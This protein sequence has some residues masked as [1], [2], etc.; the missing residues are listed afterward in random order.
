[1]EQLFAFLSSFGTW[2]LKYLPPEAVTKLQATLPLWTIG[3]IAVVVAAFVLKVVTHLVFR[4]ILWVALIVLGIIL[5]Q[6]LGVPVLATLG[7]LGNK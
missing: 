5:L 3:L 6:S 4:I 7:A 1:M 2:V